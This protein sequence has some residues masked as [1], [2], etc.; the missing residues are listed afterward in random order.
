MRESLKKKKMIHRVYRVRFLG[1]VLF[2]KKIQ[3][4]L[5]LPGVSVVLEGSLTHSV[6]TVKTVTHESFS[7]LS[8]SFLPLVA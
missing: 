4:Y 7:L 3:H 1:S 5:L 6:I 8:V 2:N